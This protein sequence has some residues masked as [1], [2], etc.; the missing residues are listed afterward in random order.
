MSSSSH[1][2]TYDV[3]EERGAW[4]D[5]TRQIVGKRRDAKVVHHFLSESEAEQLRTV[6]EVVVDDIRF[7]ILSYVVSEIDTSLA[8]PI[9]EAQ[10]KKGVP[11]KQILYRAGL[12][13]VEEAAS[14]MFQQAFASLDKE[15][16]TAILQAIE[17]SQQPQTTAWQVVPAKDFMKKIVSDIVSIYYSHP[18]V[19]S[20]IG[21]GGPAYPRGYVRVEIG[22]V[23][24]WEAK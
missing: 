22:L 23:D 17:Q 19:W 12:A 16:R 14:A 15:S 5:H 2:P 24:P 18:T 1:Y 20:E 21:Y 13:G 11:E 4:D 9:G 8:H 3:W 6:A 7:D 10:R